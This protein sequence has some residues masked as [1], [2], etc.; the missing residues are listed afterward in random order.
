VDLPLLAQLRPGDTVRFSPVSLDL[1]HA[2][3]RTR[4]QHLAR[5]N[6]AL[7]LRFA[8]GSDASR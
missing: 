4:E 5:A 8:A 3:Y 2:L 6:R 7:Q 1:A